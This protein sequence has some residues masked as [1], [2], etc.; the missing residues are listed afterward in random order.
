MPFELSPPYTPLAHV[1]TRL[2]ERGFAVLSPLDLAQ[3]VGRPGHDDPLR[4]L[5]PHWQDLPHDEHLRDA[6]RYRRR[7][8][9]SFIVS[10]QRI[11]RVP[12]RAHW[13]GCTCPMISFRAS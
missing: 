1:D 8:H 2:A 12:H 4:E 6:G 3:L 9:G 10:G 11:E 7:R 5:R 13:Q